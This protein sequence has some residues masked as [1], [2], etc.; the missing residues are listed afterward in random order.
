MAGLE[1]CESE[2]GQLAVAAVVHEDVGGLDIA[3]ENAAGMCVGQ[4]TEEVVANLSDEAPVFGLRVV[5]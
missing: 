4:A 2:V 5:P 3:V 1:L